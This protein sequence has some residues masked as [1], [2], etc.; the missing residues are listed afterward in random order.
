[1]PEITKYQINTFE[2][3]HNHKYNLTYWANVSENREIH[4]MTLSNYKIKL[5]SL[6]TGRA[7]EWIDGSY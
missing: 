1:M 4:I 3:D 7:K 5:V 2:R 6:N